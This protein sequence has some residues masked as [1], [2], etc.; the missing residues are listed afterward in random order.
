MILFSLIPDGVDKKRSGKHEEHHADRST[1]GNVFIRVA[2]GNRLNPDR[3]NRKPLHY[4]CAVPFAYNGAHWRNTTSR[5]PLEGDRAT[6]DNE[7]L[8]I[9]PGCFW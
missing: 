8:H 2:H 7:Q 4:D 5:Q 1:W 3:G 9:S 6:N